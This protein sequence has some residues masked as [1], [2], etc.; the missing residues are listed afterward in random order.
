MMRTTVIPNLAL[1]VLIAFWLAQA[2]F[3]SAQVPRDAVE[4]LRADLKA[5][6]QVAI[7]E[8]MKLTDPESEAFWPLYRSYRAETD[9]V[10]DRMVELL[11]EYADL[12]PNVPEQKAGEMLTQY[13]KT[14]EDLLAVKRKYLKKFEKVLPPS[15]VFRFAQLDSRF[16]LGTRVA[17]AARMALMPVSEAKSGNEQH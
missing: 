10:T 14:E 4:S 17:L 16:D 3:A 15:K 11:F 5:D 1:P 7:A 6:R 8:N 9:K 2:I 12:Y 13:L